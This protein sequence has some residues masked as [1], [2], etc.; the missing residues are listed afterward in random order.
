MD[1]I[2]NDVVVEWLIF[3]FEMCLFCRI[4]R[5]NCTCEMFES[6]WFGGYV[7]RERG[8]LNIWTSLFIIYCDMP[9]PRIV[10][11]FVYAFIFF[12]SVIVSFRNDIV[13]LHW[14]RYIIIQIDPLMSSSHWIKEGYVF[15]WSFCAFCLFVSWLRSRPYPIRF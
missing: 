1:L 2:L 7:L 4:S 14:P 12:R 10:E 11:L 9:C 3:R 6:F 13:F 8:N 5:D 15:T